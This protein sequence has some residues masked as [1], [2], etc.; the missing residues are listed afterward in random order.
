MKDDLVNNCK[1]SYMLA[2]ARKYYLF[3]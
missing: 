3:W 2:K 1:L